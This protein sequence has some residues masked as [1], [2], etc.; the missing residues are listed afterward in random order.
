MTETTSEIQ[1]LGQI[2]ES[3][4]WLNLILAIQLVVGIA[5]T[6]VTG[7]TV[8]RWTHFIIPFIWFTASGWVLWHTRPTSASWTY[9]VGAGLVVT[10]Y[11]LIMLYFS[12]LVGPST[13]HLGQLTG[14]TDYGVTWG[15]S[16]GWSPVLLYTG[17]I[18]TATIIPY[19]AVG[20]FAMAYLVYD[21]LLS[22]SQSAVGGVIGIA[23]CPACVSPI[24]LAL[25]G[26]MGG[27]TTTIL[28]GTYGYEFATVL[29]LLGLAILYH[30]G[31]LTIVVSQI[32]GS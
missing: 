25:A 18:I 27:T 20:L 29:F 12:G 8:G 14:A 7:D 21:A 6:Y 23:A 22:L 13:S 2:L 31:R 26:G 19:Q 11:F 1:F 10:M 5:Y 30:R 17:N 16:L 3:S 24:A 4:T 9:R 32:R 15:R 28:L